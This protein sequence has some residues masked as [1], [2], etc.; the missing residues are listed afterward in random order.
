MA[1]DPSIARAKAALRRE[2]AARCRALAA[3]AGTR[4][5][6]SLADQGLS[7]LP[8]PSGRRIA[9]YLPFDDEI[10]PLPLMTALAARGAALLLPVVRAPDAPL[11]FR[12][13]RPGD[14]TV[15][16]LHGNAEPAADA[17][18]DEPDWVLVPLR[19]FDRR[20]GRLGRG[21]GCYDRTLAG[22]RARGAWLVGLAFACQEVDAVPM[23]P[24]DVALDAVLTEAGLVTCAPQRRDG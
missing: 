11:E 15:R 21:R 3:G 6:L 16:G 20:G 13:W 7:A 5:A 9:G 22:L 8:D 14:R 4:A 10:D 12:R 23:E 1:A 19:A 17:A 18:V 2:M 24:H